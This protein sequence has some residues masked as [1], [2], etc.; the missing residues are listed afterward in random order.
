MEDSCKFIALAVMSHRKG[1]V[2][3]L[4]DGAADNQEHDV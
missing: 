1:V 4:G 3:Q 2:T